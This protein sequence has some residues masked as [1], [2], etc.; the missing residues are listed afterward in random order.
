[1]R[2]HMPLSHCR[3]AGAAPQ[4][5]STRTAAASPASA[6]VGFALLRLLSLDPSL[7]DWRLRDLGIL[8]AIAPT[9]TVPRI[10]PVS[11]SRAA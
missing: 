10:K 5:T 2:R 8:N 7:K 6:M 3:T 4:C 9:C 1:M 11:A